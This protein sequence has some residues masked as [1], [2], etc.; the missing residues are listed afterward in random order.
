MENTQAVPSPQGRKRKERVMRGCDRSA[1][2]CQPEP[3][4][5]K[6]KHPA[7][8]AGIAGAAPWA[9]RASVGHLRSPARTQQSPSPTHV[10]PQ[11]HPRGRRAQEMLGESAFP[12]LVTSSEP[13]PPPPPA[14]SKLPQK[15]LGFLERESVTLF[16]K[17]P[18]S[19]YCWL[20]RRHGLTLLSSALVGLK[21]P[22]IHKPM[23]CAFAQ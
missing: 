15:D 9:S 11:C 5:C 7:R 23:G 14:G 21:L 19:E 4:I 6:K 12:P 20:C 18:A 3:W 16:C 13:P 8:N 22:E 17:G 10:C 1:E 2:K